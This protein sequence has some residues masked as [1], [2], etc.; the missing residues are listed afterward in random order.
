ML[1]I[2]EFI[3]SSFWTWLGSLM[4]LTVIV[5]GITGLMGSLYTLL[6]KWVD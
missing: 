5:N 1:A 4:M 6:F 3:F 2:L